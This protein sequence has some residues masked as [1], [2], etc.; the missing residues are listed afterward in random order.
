MLR[1]LF[2]AVLLAGWALVSGPA[3][4]KV[5]QVDDGGFVIRLSAT[6]PASPEATWQELVTPAHWW[7]PEHSYSGDSSNFSL[8]QHPG[9]CFCEA[10]PDSSAELAVPLGGVEHMRVLYIEKDRQLRMAGGLGP[11]QSEAVVGTLTIA[12]K[13][14]EAGTRILWE[15]VV[16]GYMRLKPAEIAPAVDQVLGG[17]LARLALNL[18]A[19]IETSDPVPVDPAQGR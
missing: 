7:N 6:V 12:L 3:Q 13:P 11:L 15:Y 8:E 19:G 14:D 18:G 4:A 5:H 2:C 17:Q 9:G 16:G 1:S 10:L